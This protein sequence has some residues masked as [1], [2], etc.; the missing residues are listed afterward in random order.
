MPIYKSGGKLAHRQRGRD[1]VKVYRNTNL[2][3]QEFLPDGTVLFAGPAIFIGN[4]DEDLA[5][6]R[7]YIDKTGMKVYL[8]TTVPLAGPIH[9]L[10]TGIKLTGC[11]DFY[12]WDEPYYNRWDVKLYEDRSPENAI[13][14]M[15]ISREDLLSHKIIQVNAPTNGISFRITMQA[16]DDTHIKVVSQ[17]PYNLNPWPNSTQNFY[18]GSNNYY[19]YSPIQSITAY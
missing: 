1:I 12:I 6:Q 2:V 9:K 4:E 13:Q 14:N 3:F 7:P 18:D 8:N 10:K 19:Y 5:A 11:G 15:T 16:I 17:D